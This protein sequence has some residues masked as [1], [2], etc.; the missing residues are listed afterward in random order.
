MPPLT[1]CMCCFILHGCVNIREVMKNHEDTSTLFLGVFTNHS[2]GVVGEETTVLIR[3]SNMHSKRDD[4]R[5]K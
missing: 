4:E 2:K 1:P 5:V 3:L